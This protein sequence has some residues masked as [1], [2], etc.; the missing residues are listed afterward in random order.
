MSTI[1]SQKGKASFHLFELQ[2]VAST[3]VCDLTRSA[4]ALRELA[5]EAKTRSERD[6]L[7]Y[8]AEESVLEARKVIVQIYGDTDRAIEVEQLVHE[9]VSAIQM[10]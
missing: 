10:P 5:A 9:A 2:Q 6:A 3:V 8:E 1:K 7:R 4:V